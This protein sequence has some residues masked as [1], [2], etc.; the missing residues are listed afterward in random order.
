MDKNNYTDAKVRKRIAEMKL[1]HVTRMIV[2][3]LIEG[4]RDEARAQGYKDGLKAAKQS[5]AQCQ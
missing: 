4:V 5:A 3:N 2:L 1:P